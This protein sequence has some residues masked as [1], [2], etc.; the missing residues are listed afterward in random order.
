M[1]IQHLGFRFLFHS[2]TKMNKR[3]QSVLSLESADPSFRLRKIWRWFGRNHTSVKLSNECKLAH[4]SPAMLTAGVHAI[5]PA[6]MQNQHLCLKCLPF[7]KG[8]RTGVPQSHCV[9]QENSTQSYKALRSQRMAEGAWHSLQALQMRV[10]SGGENQENWR[11]NDHTTV[12]LGRQMI[13]STGKLYF[14]RCRSAS[15][16]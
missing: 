6:Y 15:L 9:I 8:N 16:L 1:L 13:I 4:G 10:H 7:P 2:Q 14:S 12:P 5:R 11:G 3:Q